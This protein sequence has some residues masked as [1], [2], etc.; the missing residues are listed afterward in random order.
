M[1]V[2]CE[3]QPGTCAMLSW[4]GPVLSGL[5]YYHIWRALWAP[6]TC[7]FL[8]I[9]SAWCDSIRVRHAVFCSMLLLPLSLVRASPSCKAD[10]VL[11][12]SLSH[13]R[14][15][16]RTRA[17]THTHSVFLL[18]CQRPRFA[19]S[20]ALFDLSELILKVTSWTVYSLVNTVALYCASSLLR[21][22]IN[23]LKH[24]D[25]YMYRLL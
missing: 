10:I 4:G 24:S 7:T 16:A 9:S 19:S 5:P 6:H 17:R 13:A 2:K 14:V 15:H 18:H 23:H 20:T 3:D 21:C 1:Q 22:L 8:L 11:S 12:C 25:N